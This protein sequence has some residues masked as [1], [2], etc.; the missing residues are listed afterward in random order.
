[1][2][3]LSAQGKCFSYD[4]RGSGFGRGEGAGC[5]LIKRLDDAIRDGDPIQAIIRNTAV[6]LI[7]LSG[8]HTPA[9][10]GKRPTMEAVQTVSQYPL[11][12]RKK[13]CCEESTSRSA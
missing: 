7:Q 6:S 10:I 2:G 8:L 13:P 12:L 9:N 3:A 4:P 1:M 5:L 11:V